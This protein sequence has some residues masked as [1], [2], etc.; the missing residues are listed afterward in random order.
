VIYSGGTRG[1]RTS[2]ARA[3][4]RARVAEVAF[5]GGGYHKGPIGCS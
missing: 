3:R 1:G 4:A 2:S 5:T